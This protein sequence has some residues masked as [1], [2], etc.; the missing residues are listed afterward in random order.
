[1]HIKSIWYWS[2]FSFLKGNLIK[3][4]HI[5]PQE[6][7]ILLQNNLYVA[8][9]VNMQTI[10]V[11]WIMSLISVAQTFNFLFFSKFNTVTYVTAVRD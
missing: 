7:V 3:V 1:M 6:A 4:T 2:Q 8:K 10:L 9:E 5:T 11:I